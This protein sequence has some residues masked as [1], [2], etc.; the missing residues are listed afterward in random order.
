VSESGL[1]PA[2]AVVEDTL[3]A[4]RAGSDHC[5][6]IVEETSEVEVRFV[7][8]GEHR[9]RVELEHRHIDRHGDGW[10]NMRDA[11]GSPE[12]WGSGLQHFVRRL[13]RSP[14]GDM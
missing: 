7:P 9:T 8:E 1:P 11:V 4:A 12:G 10:E 3:A 14:V 2:Q 13:E 5:V 6:V